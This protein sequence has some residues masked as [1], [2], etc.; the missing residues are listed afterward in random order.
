MTELSLSCCAVLC[1][2][3]CA[4]GAHPKA[5]PRAS[6]CFLTA[7]R[8]GGASS[9]AAVEHTAESDAEA[10]QRQLRFLAWMSKHLLD[11]MYAGE[12]VV[13]VVSGLGRW[14][15]VCYTLLLL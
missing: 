8:P 9:H 15:E 2:C 1:C 10:E 13:V 3:P 7:R 12:E 11:S 6:R 5:L 14:D 4:G